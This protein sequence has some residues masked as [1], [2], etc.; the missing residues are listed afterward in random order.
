MRGLFLEYLSLTSFSKMLQL[1]ESREKLSSAWTFQYIYCQFVG[2]VTKSTGI[3]SELLGKKTHF[4]SHKNQ[5]VKEY[6]L[7]KYLE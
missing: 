5:N 7:L 2:Q 1:T 3:N 6:F 4:S